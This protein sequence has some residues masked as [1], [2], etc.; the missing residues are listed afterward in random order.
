[1]SLIALVY[2]SVASYPMSD[3]ELKEILAVARRN[4]SERNVTGMLLYRDEYFIQALEG[5]EAD[6]NA[7]YDKICQDKRHRNI[8]TVYKNPIV[9]RSFDNWSMG[10]NHI[11]DINPNELPGFTDFL[12]KPFDPVFLTGQPSRAKNLLEHFKDRTFF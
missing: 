11:R 12:N 2:V 9:A 10:F 3:D 8:I 4:N 6:V 1:M 7:I 5:E